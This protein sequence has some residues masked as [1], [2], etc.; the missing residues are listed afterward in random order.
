MVPTG[1]VGTMAGGHR[2]GGAGRGVDEGGGDPTGFEFGVGGRFGVDG[3]LPGRGDAIVS[4]PFVK[5]IS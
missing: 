4:L 1:K 5:L 2:E 3:A